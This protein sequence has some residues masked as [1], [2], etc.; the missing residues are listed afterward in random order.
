MKKIH[1]MLLV[2]VGKSQ[3]PEEVRMM[4]EKENGEKDKIKEACKG[5]EMRRCK[6]LSSNKQPRNVLVILVVD[7]NK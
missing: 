4:R 2:D 5:K 1:W 3:Q 6:A 7:R